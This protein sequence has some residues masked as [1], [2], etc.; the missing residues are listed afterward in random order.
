ML[1]DHLQ[2]IVS[3]TTTTSKRS[4]GGMSTEF[5]KF[6]KEAINEVAKKLKD[7]QAQFQLKY[8]CIKNK[9]DTFGSHFMDSDKMGY[10]KD[11]LAKAHK[12]CDQQYT[13]KVNRYFIH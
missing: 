13:T 9:M 1:S 12:N 6:S 4:V 7:S 2:V 10:S 5:S 8:V 3:V 11:D